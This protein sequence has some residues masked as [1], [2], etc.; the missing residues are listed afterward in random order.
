M[1]SSK[2]YLVKAIIKYHIQLVQGLLLESFSR[3]S[4]YDAEM[5]PVTPAAKIK[6][7]LSQHLTL[8]SMSKWLI[9]KWDSNR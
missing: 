6:L 2:A 8:Y 5:K 7:K 9:W 1:F 3:D 4:L